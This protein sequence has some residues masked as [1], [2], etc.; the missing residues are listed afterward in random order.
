MKKKKIVPSKSAS[1]IAALKKQAAGLIRRAESLIA[2][3]KKRFNALDP[4][5]KKQLA[6]AA[7]GLA[8]VA[9]MA[10]RQKKKIAK[11]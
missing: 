5:T 9:V 1:E 4:A 7:A 6:A 8:L 10:A 11:K 2:Q 3:A